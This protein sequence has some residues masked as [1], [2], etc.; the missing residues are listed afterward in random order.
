MDTT[1]K[2]LN[3]PKNNLQSN[4]TNTHMTTTT[5]Q[6]NETPVY[7]DRPIYQYSNVWQYISIDQP[8]IKISARHTTHQLLQNACLIQYCLVDL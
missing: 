5:G 2:K 1:Q 6:M 7:S 8:D 4:S 3:M